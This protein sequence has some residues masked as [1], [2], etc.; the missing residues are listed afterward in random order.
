MKLFLIHQP[1]EIFNMTKHPNPKSRRGGVL[2]M[3]A[4]MLPVTVGISAFAINIAYMELNRTEM[5]V[6]ADAAARA[7]GRE[8]ALQ[9]DQAKA[10]TAGKNAAERNPVAGKAFALENSDFVFGEATRTSEASRYMFTKGGANPNAVEV[11]IK[12]VAGSSNGAL[13][14]LIPYSGFSNS[15]NSTITSR[16]NQA[17]ADI[18][19]VIDRSGSMAYASNEKAVYPPLPKAAAPA[20]WFDQPA[21]TPSRWRDLVGSVDVFLKELD[22]TP[23][24]E[25]ISLVTY[26]SASGADVPLTTKYSDINAGLDKYTK[27]FS[28]GS[29]SIAS[30]VDSG[31]GILSGKDARQFSTKV[32]VLMT[33]GIDTTGSD[34][35]KAAK[36]AAEKGIMIFTVTF[37]DEADKTTMANVANTGLGKHYHAMN[38]T[39]LQNIFL[40]ISRQIPVLISR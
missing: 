19:L 35:N 4:I 33:D 10:I 3:F 26:S 21:P 25:T 20:W 36:A 1:R 17:E 2:P 37:S 32:M 18:C 28:G 7:A 9:W 38:A 27:V 34:V 16:A 40:E 11:D 31:V 14:M 15:V 29:T 8:F 6:A 30:G 22:K 13:T 23:M 39:D 12:R 5:Y 24:K